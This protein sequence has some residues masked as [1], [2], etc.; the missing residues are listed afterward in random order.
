MFVLGTVIWV[1]NLKW[2]S[3]SQWKTA[4][5]NAVVVDGIIEGFVKS[6]NNLSLYWVNRAGHMVIK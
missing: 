2:A 3:K 4:A 6:V 1:D 5:R